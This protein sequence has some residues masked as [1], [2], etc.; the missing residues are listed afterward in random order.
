MQC[1]LTWKGGP[2]EHLT[3]MLME[4]TA[5]ELEHGP[6]LLQHVTSTPYKFNNA[7]RK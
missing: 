5:P 6:T 4:P 2:S 3:C 7:C 1:W